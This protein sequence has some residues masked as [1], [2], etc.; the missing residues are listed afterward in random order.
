[1]KRR[2][3]IKSPSS[4]RFT[5]TTLSPRGAYC[6]ASSFSMGY[7]SRQGSHHVAQKFTSS[8]FPR[9][10]CTSFSYPLLSISSGSCGGATLGACGAA[11]PAVPTRR[12]NNTHAA[13]KFMVLPFPFILSIGRRLR[14]SRAPRTMSVAACRCKQ[15]HGIRTVLPVIP[16]HRSSRRR[17][18]ETKETL[19]G[20]RDRRT[21]HRHKRH[22]VRGRLPGGLHSPPQR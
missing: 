15:P 12:H 5:P 21:L 2:I 6:L 17:A 14:N 10:C 7:S 13:R 20:L 3:R 9:Y 22:R 18:L 1:M 19:N 4:S 16:L 8:G 11:T